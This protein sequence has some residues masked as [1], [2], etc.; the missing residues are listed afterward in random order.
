M[1]WQTERGCVGSKENKAISSQPEMRNEANIH[2][3]SVCFAVWV[4]AAGAI[5]HRSELMFQGRKH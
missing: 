1:N 2:L 4:D 3:F 5:A